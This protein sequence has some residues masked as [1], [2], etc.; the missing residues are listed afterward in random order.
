MLQTVE[1]IY[2]NG[3]IELTEA[4]QGLVESRVI[5]TFLGAESSASI[6]QMMRFDMFPGS[7]LSTEAD[8]QSAEFH[9]D[10]DDGLAWS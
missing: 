2:K 8:F 5:V 7:N 6:G 1:G 4:P 10:A 9:G 3:K